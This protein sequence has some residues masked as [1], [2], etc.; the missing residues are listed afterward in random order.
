MKNLKWIIVCLCLLVITGLSLLIEGFLIII[1]GFD[2]VPLPLFL[3][4]ATSFG[5]VFVLYVCNLVK[6][7][8]HS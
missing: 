7:I 1:G 2:I 8:Q 4:T 3:G 5:V 6:A